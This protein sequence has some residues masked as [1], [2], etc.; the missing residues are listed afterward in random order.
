MAENKTTLPV[1]GGSLGWGGLADHGDRFIGSH[2]SSDCLN[3][4]PENGILKKRKGYTKDNGGFVLGGV[5]EAA[6]TGNI[7]LDYAPGNIDISQEVYLSGVGSGADIDFTGTITSLVIGFRLKGYSSTSSIYY[8]A[9]IYTVDGNGHPDTLIATSTSSISESTISKTSE[10]WVY[11]N[12]TNVTLGTNHVCIGFGSSNTSWVG[13]YVY[14]STGGGGYAPGG[15]RVASYG[16]TGSWTDIT[17]DFLFRFYYKTTTQSFKSLVQYA[18]ASSSSEYISNNFNFTNGSSN[19]FG[20]IAAATSILQNYSLFVEGDAVGYRV[21]DN[22]EGDLNFIPEYGGT[23]GYKSVRFIKN[24]LI[25]GSSNYLFESSFNNLALR[26]QKFT[27]ENNYYRFADTQYGLVVCPDKN[28]PQI[29]GSTAYPITGYTGTMAF[30]GLTNPV[31]Q[32]DV[33][34]WHQNRCWVGNVTINS[35]SYVN[36]IY[37]S[38]STTPESGYGDNNWINTDAK[39]TALIDVGD[40]AIVSDLNNTYIL[41]GAATVSTLEFVK[42]GVGGGVT[43][44][45][46][47]CAWRDSSGNAYVFGWGDRGIFQIDRTNKRYIND[48]IINKLG[49]LIL[50]DIF[51]CSD[52]AR[53]LILFGYAESGIRKTLGYHVATDTWWPED[54]AAEMMIPVALPSSSIQKVYG[55]KT[56]EW[57]NMYTGNMD[58]GNFIKGYYKTGPFYIDGTKFKPRNIYFRNRNEP[59][60]SHLDVKVSNDYGTDTTTSKAIR[61]STYANNVPVLSKTYS[62]GGEATSSEITLYQDKV[63]TTVNVNSDSGQAVLSVASVVG[64][65]I[66]HKIVINDG[67]AREETKVISSIGTTS[68]TFTTNLTYTHTAAQADAVDTYDESFAIGSVEMEIYGSNKVPQEL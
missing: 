56:N 21:S 48:K 68:L 60:V 8:F 39:T 16:K 13:S 49:S 66:G 7:Q 34:M 45:E 10:H 15:A 6:S 3:V 28:V 14:Y 65:I 11:W 46:A 42:H 50:S 32:A 2:E 41:L 17:G 29:W 1:A 33:V 20:I 24:R 37:Y 47:M 22:Y 52:Y 54:T 58:D 25:L 44:Q 62:G 30:T 31:T 23:T 38:G 12:F 43:R 67:G 55:I 18:D 9:K 61:N 59:N 64:F 53:G 5:Y 4:Y 35:V 57:W 27:T 26:I 19:A 36:R 51:V 40:Y 63:S